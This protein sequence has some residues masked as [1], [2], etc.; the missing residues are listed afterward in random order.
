[1]LL[2]PL[3]PLPPIGPL[4]PVL[5]PDTGAV[6]PVSVV[7][8]PTPMP[9]VG[10]EL[11]PA[12]GIEP[13]PAFGVPPEPPPAGGISLDDPAIEP[14]SEPPVLAPLILASHCS[15][16]SLQAAMTTLRL[17]AAPRGLE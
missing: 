2:P 4:P 15:L 13:L 6:P 5:E 1:M 16:P 10:S 9:P 11:D 14:E 7:L 17:S 3:P 8:P 12:V